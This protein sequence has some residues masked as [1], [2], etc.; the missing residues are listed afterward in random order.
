MQTAMGRGLRR[1]VCCAAVLLAVP[2]LWGSAVWAA[3]PAAAAGQEQSL[4]GR[5]RNADGALPDG[6]AL[7][8]GRLENRT[9]RPCRAWVLSLGPQG[10]VHRQLRLDAGQSADCLGAGERLVLVRLQTGAR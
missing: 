7:A 1:A 8:A 10:A 2:L 4:A 9:G 6:L 3:R 5:A